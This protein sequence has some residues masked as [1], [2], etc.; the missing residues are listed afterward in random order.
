MAAIGYALAF[1]RVDI[2][3]D[4]VN[5]LEGVAGGASVPGMLVKLASTGKYVVHATVDGQGEL[6]VV[7]VNSFEG[8]DLSET[9]Y[10]DT[11]R[12]FMHHPQRGD[13]FLALIKDGENIAI[14]DHLASNG[15]GTFKKYD[16]PAI[17]AIMPHVFAIAEDALD[18]TAAGANH[19]V[20]ARAL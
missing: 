5:R 10:A 17:D 4:P 20:V 3:I 2:D 16:A 11:N 8:D 18:L 6:L 12:I 9:V 19:H 7:G 13:K 1:N 15:D 14:G